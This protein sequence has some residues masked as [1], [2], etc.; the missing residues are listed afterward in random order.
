[1][2]DFEK[3][4]VGPTT[5]NNFISLKD[6]MM[7]KIDYEKEKELILQMD[8]E[9]DEYDVIHSIDINTLKKF[10]IILIEFHNS[11]IFL[12]LYHNKITNIFKNSRTFYLYTYTSK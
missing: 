7:T 3:K 10:R 12:I 2:I 8:I 5:H 9:G 1:M 11:I 6:W 4:F